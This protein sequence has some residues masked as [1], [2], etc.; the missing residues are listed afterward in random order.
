[1]SIYVSVTY[2]LNESMMLVKSN[3]SRR[4]F[5]MKVAERLPI[6]AGFCLT[7]SAVCVTF[8]PVFVGW[9]TC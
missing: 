4:M 3:E 1:M 2:N 6:S 5:D 7:Q 9:L 8:T